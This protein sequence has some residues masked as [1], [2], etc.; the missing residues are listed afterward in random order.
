MAGLHFYHFLDLTMSNDWL[1][2]KRVC[3]TKNVQN[4]QM[5]SADFREEIAS[6]LCNMSTKAHRT[7]RSIEPDIQAISIRVQPNMSRQYLYVMIKLGIGLYWSRKE[8]AASIRTV[9][10]YHKRSVNS[11]EQLCAITSQSSASKHSIHHRILGP[12]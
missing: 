10:A 11:M 2:Y 4:T 9:L 3:K 6:V 12:T 8:F 5:S 7:G 1:L